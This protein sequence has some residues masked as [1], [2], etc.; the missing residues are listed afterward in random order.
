MT[1]TSAKFL[2]VLSVLGCASFAQAQEAQITAP[3]P[4]APVRSYYY[5]RSFVTLIPTVGAGATS[6]SVSGD[7]DTSSTNTATGYR[8]GMLVEL[9]RNTFSFQTGVMYQHEGAQVSTQR[10]LRHQRRLLHI[11]EPTRR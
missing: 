5:T 9:G 8:G 1:S 2:M 11:S 4:V 10:S 7:T 3:R 6:L